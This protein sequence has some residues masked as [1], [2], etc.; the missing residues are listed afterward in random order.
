MAV[1]GRLFPGLSGISSSLHVEF[2]VVFK[3]TSLLHVLFVVGRLLLVISVADGLVLSGSQT[4]G[5]IRVGSNL[6]RLD[7]LQQT[8]ENTVG[9]VGSSYSLLSQL[10]LHQF[11]Y[12]LL[13]SGS[14]I[15][16]VLHRCP[17]VHLEDLETREGEIVSTYV[18]DHEDQDGSSVQWGTKHANGLTGWFA[19]PPLNQLPYRYW[20]THDHST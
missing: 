13:G 17:Q 6:S 19:S 20:H 12:C 16:R 11:T 5:N 10:S 18:V 9:L 7:L 4:S 1:G 2:S 15:V 14:I 8:D 3:D